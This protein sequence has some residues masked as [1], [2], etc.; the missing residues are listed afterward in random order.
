MIYVVTKGNYSDYHIVSATT[1]EETAKLIAK[2]YDA[3]IERYHDGKTLQNRK[4]YSFIVNRK[5]EI[6]RYEKAEEIGEYDYNDTDD[7]YEFCGR[8]HYHIY[9]ENEESAFKKLYDMIAI[10]KAEKE[11]I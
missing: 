11:Q 10:Q 4:L 7:Y 6:D 3:S 8:Y 2:R 1:D 9:S 5:F